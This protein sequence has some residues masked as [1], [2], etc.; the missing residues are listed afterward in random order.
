MQ[1]DVLT[2]VDHPHATISR[3]LWQREMFWPIVGLECQGWRD[4]N[5]TKLLTVGCGGKSQLV[6]NRV[7]VEKVT[8]ISR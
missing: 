7:G 5:S 3:L 4:G 1:P 8:E 2:F 6:M